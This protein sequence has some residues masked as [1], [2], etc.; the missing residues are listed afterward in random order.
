ME[1]PIPGKSAIGIEVPNKTATTVYLREL[2]ETPD[3]Q[4]SKSKT[5]ICV[6]KDVAGAPVFSD[7]AKMPHLLVAGATG[8]GKSVCMNSFMMSMLYKAKPDEVRFIMIDPKQVEFMKYNGIPHLLVPVVDNAK[9]AAGSLMWA[10]EEMTRRY[11]LIKNL[12]V[13]N[14][15]EY[16]E[17]VKNNPELGEFLPRIVIVID[18]FADLM[19]EVKDPVENL[20]LNLAQK[21]RA[22]GIHLIVGTQRPDVNV[23]TG[24]IKANIP[25]RISCKVA[26]HNDSRTI[27]E[28]AGAEKLLDRGDMLFSFAG[29]I[30][31]I[32]VQ[33]AFVSSGELEEILNFIK[34]QY[35]G[36][37]YD[38]EVLNEIN[39]AASKCGKK[40]GMDDDDDDNEKSQG[41]SGKGP[42]DDPQ[43]LDAVDVALSQGQISTALLQR[44]LSIGFGKAA[45]FI[46]YMEDMGLVSEKNGAKPRNVL[47][48]RE[49]WLAKYDRV[50]L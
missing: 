1:A 41:G 3:F 46:D 44:R 19:L 9:Q 32:R 13:S 12:F 37:S 38:E 30:K 42:L 8:M 49:E 6:G 40:A 27:L 11:G 10:V 50:S 16:N 47:L 7:I 24:T 15:E 29:A 45:R 36:D 21:A 28:C 5:T 18:E 25:S 39:R 14:I 35:D 4:T 33:G 20:V 17:K 48:T 26:S 2:I 34:S 23:I 43:F 22:A 31:P